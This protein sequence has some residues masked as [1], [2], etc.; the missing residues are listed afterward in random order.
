[1]SQTATSNLNNQTIAGGKKAWG[2]TFSV[3][4]QFKNALKLTFEINFAPGFSFDDGPTDARG[5]VGGIFVGSGSASGCNHSEAAS[6][7]L[8]WE[9]QRSAQAYTYI[10]TS[11]RG[12]QPGFV[13]S[14]G[15]PNC[16]LGIW[17]SDFNNIFK[18]TGTWNTVTLGVK[19][20]TVG[21]N[22]GKIYMSITN[23]ERT[24]TRE[25]DG[26]V[27]RTKDWPI[28]SI[29]FNSFFGGDVNMGRVKPSTFQIRNI[30]AG[31]Y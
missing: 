7:R 6:L 15:D 18:N 3:P 25:S 29:S 20:N 5:K 23:N 19:L 22:D 16:G 2:K 14:M 27:W 26:F 1:M 21:K 24:I 31:P 17:R 30:R 4:S 28:T 12:K 9:H 11:S 10:P 8:M 13:K